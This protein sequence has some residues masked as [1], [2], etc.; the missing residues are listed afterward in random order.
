MILNSIEY[1]FEMYCQCY[2]V[3]FSKHNLRA[4]INE[5]NYQRYLINLLLSLG[6]YKKGQEI[7]FYNNKP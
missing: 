7:V 2:S 6:I 5:Y 1:S 4:N 3:S